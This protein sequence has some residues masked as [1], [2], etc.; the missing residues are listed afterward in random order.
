MSS[1][2]AS[3]P[4]LGQSQQRYMGEEITNEYLDMVLESLSWI[5]K[6]CQTNWKVEVFLWCLLLHF[7]LEWLRDAPSLFVHFVDPF[8]CI[9][10]NKHP[11]YQSTIDM[12]IRSFCVLELPC[13]F[14]RCS[15]TCSEKW[16]LC[17]EL[18]NLQD[19]QIQWQ[20]ANFVGTTYKWG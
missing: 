10:N 1:H 4:S 12:T 20:L 17:L 8:V 18:C 16:I 13:T 14:T 3:I 9:T 7:I 2:H 19:L 6:A 11:S 5:N 15:L